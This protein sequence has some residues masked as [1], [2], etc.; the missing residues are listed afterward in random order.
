[1]TWVTHRGLI[2]LKVFSPVFHKQ[3]FVANSSIFRTDVV[4]WKYL[5]FFIAS[6]A[7]HFCQFSHFFAGGRVAVMP[8]LIRD[9]WRHA[10]LHT[11]GYALPNHP[12]STHP[13]L[14]SPIFRRAEIITSFS[15]SIMGTIIQ[16]VL[17]N[18]NIRLTHSA[19][20]SLNS[21]I[22][23]FHKDVFRISIFVVILNWT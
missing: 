9:P 3:L 16:S 5:W 21:K 2:S 6:K 1:M 14:R 20:L 12:R 23:Y 7:R 15:F 18:T 19:Y 17:Y 13:C 8:G 11:S 10:G 4:P 22:I